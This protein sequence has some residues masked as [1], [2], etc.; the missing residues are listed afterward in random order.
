M[1]MCEKGSLNQIKYM[2]YV[3]TLLVVVA[4]Y[5]HP[6]PSHAI[7]ISP[8]SHLPACLPACLANC[9][10]SLKYNHLAYPLSILSYLQ[11]CVR[12]S[13]RTN[14]LINSLITRLSV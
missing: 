2:I 6:I 12:L 13:L 5:I 9:L 8:S 7:T 11:C 10:R 3:S 4:I 14:S 1:C